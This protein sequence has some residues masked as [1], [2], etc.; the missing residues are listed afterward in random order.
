MVVEDAD[1]V[2]LALAECA[3]GR[4]DFADALI[5]HRNL[6]A[7]CDTTLT[8]DTRLRRCKPFRVL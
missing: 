2:R 4:A 3:T 5:G 1:L 7:G 6:K 8:F